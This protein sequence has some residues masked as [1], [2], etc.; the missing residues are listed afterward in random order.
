M[1]LRIKDNVDLKELEKFGFEKGYSYR[2]ARNEEGK[3]IKYHK[4][5]KDGT[6]TKKEYIKYEIDGLIYI[7]EIKF[8]SDVWPYYDLTRYEIKEYIDGDFK[9]YNRLIYVY[10]EDN[11]ET[12]N[13]VKCDTLF[14]LI[15]AG[16]VEKVEDK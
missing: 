8:E 10:Q 6:Y 16:L 11:L 13:Y 1:A 2:C 15:Q 3:I 5:K 14:D 12:I 4:K 9:T 7:K